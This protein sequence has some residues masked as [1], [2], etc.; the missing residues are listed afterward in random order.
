MQKEIQKVSLEENQTIEEDAVSSDIKKIKGFLVK[1]ISNILPFLPH[2]RSL[3]FKNLKKIILLI[4]VLSLLGFLVY[5]GIKLPKALLSRKGQVNIPQETNRTPT[6]V[7]YTPYLPSV[8]ADDPEILRLEEDVRVLENEVARVNIRE[9]KL[10]P[11]R[12][13]FNIS[14]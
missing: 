2:P 4:S 9:V 7:P 13:D 8:Y 14:F 3:I 12:L 5:F 11:P 6:A 1:L 10:I